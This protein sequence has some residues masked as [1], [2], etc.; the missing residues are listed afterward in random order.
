MLTRPSI[1]NSF[2]EGDQRSVRP[3]G[4]AENNISTEKSVR[5]S[6]LSQMCKEAATSSNAMSTFD[7]FSV[8]ISDL[9]KDYELPEHIKLSYY[10]LCCS[11]NELLHAQLQL[12]NN[13][14]VGGTIIETVNIA[15]ALRECE[16]STSK[17]EFTIW[18][19]T[20]N[21]LELL[22]MNV[23][24]MRARLLCLQEIVH[25]PEVPTFRKKCSEL[26][27]ENARAE[28]EIRSVEAK[29]AEKKKVHNKHA[30]DI[31]Y[32]KS[33]IENHE[34]KFQEQLHALW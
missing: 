8:V 2:A 11:Q 19:K 7:N 29:L 22:G 1:G 34:L 17:D 10:E 16:L 23:G 14:F 3:P 9:L 28:E 32:L 4:N 26:C 20:L 31:A 25:D 5:S 30:A 15:N 18:D 24:F 13:I 27:F 12:M 33:K 21:A 6:S